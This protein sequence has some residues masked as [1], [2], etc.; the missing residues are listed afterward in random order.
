MRSMVVNERPASPIL[1]IRPSGIK[2]AAKLD[3][4][5]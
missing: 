1:V 5:H 2:S 3:A 4:E